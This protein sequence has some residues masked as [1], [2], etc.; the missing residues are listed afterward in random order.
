MVRQAG[1]EPLL[2]PLLEISALEDYAAFDAIVVEMDSFDWAVFISTNAVHHGLKRV[3]SQRPLPVNL[4]WAAIGPATADAMHF[5]GIKQVLTPK[6]KFDSE[7]LLGLPELQKINGKRFV[8]FRGIGGRDVLAGRLAERGAEV[9]FAES[10]RRTKSPLD[11]T[12]LHSLWQNDRVHAIVITSSEA[13]QYFVACVQAH[14]WLSAVPL[15]VN[16]A[17]ISLKAS[18]QGLQAILAQNSSDEGMLQALMAWRE[19]SKKP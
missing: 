14:P 8:I 19:S 16:H 10:Y 17:R 4:N 18:E 9:V 13:L 6:N 12:L 11:V 1:G 2:F 5:Y 3:L 15:L 7:G